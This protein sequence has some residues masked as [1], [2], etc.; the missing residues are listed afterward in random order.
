MKSSEPLRGFSGSRRY[1]LT[2]IP[3]LPQ[4]VTTALAAGRLTT[5][6]AWRRPVPPCCG[7][8]P[9]PWRGRCCAGAGTAACAEHALPAV[10]CW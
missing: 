1:T 4:P 5:P 3:P 9:L 2:V 7:I 8:P 6:Y 10:R